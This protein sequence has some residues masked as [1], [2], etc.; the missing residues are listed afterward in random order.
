M[1]LTEENTHKLSLMTLALPIVHA[2]GH[3][4]SCQI[5]YSTRWTQGCGLTDGEQMERLW[6]FL[7]KMAFVTKEMTPSHRDDLL[8]DALLHYA[9]KQLDRI[10]DH[11]VD[12]MD[13]ARKLQSMTLIF[14]LPHVNPL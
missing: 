1:K 11:L 3:K 13:K 5:S 6:A 10:D 4:T 14:F 7:I 9:R 12:A 2:Y 8:T